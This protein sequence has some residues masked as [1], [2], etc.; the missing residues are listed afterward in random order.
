MDQNKIKKIVSEA[1]NKVVT[2]NTNGKL[3]VED[4]FDISQLTRQKMLSISTDMRI[5]IQGRGFGFEL[6]EEGNSVDE[7][8][9]NMLKVTE[10]RKKLVS[11]GFKQ[12]QIKSQIS[13][14]KVRVVILYGDVAMN[15]E[16]II[17]EMKS[18]GWSKSRISEPTEINGV[19]CRVLE[20]DPMVQKDISEL[21]TTE[22]VGF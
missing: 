22:V 5:F 20:F 14:N 9:Q 3:R 16:L 2:E 15:T 19:K 17:N 1:I 13:A 18:F 6:T 11:L 4:Y 7:R 21:P 12:W 8:N 10:L